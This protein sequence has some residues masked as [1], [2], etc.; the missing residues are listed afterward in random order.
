MILEGLKTCTNCKVNKP[1]SSFHKQKHGKFGVRGRCI[2]CAYSFDSKYRDA[3]A[4]RYRESHR[5]TVNARSRAF[6]KANPEKIALFALKRRYSEKQ[7]T[8]MWADKRA[9]K[10]IYLKR[11]ELNELAGFAK[12]HVDHIIPLKAKIAS[13]LH[14]PSNL[15]IVEATYNLSK[16]NKFE[17]CIS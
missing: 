11:D 13:G 3:I 1:I 16:K 5:E 15:Q 6:S 14:V 12:Y 10:Q 2:Q 7:A 4:K 17:E 8:P 9:I